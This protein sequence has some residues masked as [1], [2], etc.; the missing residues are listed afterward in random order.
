MIALG[1][2]CTH[3]VEFTFRHPSNETLVAR[4]G[5]DPRR[6][7][8]YVEVEDDGARVVTYEALVTEQAVLDVLDVLANFGFIGA[9]ACGRPARLRVRDPSRDPP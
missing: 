2:P 1:P 3:R 4:Y 6:G 7:G 5:L 8:I 9:R